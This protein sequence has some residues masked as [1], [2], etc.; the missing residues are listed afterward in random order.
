MP[1]RFLRR[2]ELPAK[3]G[4]LFFGVGIH[5]RLLLEGL[6]PLAFFDQL[7]AHLI[8]VVLLLERDDR[9]L[10]QVPQLLVPLVNCP[11]IDYGHVRFVQQ[12]PLS[13]TALEYLE[14][15]VKISLEGLE[16]AWGRDLL[17]DIVGG[18]DQM[19]QDVLAHNVRRLLPLFADELLDLVLL[20]EATPHYD[21]KLAHMQKL[22]TGC[23]HGETY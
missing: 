15:V 21:L 12:Q 6:P 20:A 8:V 3:P 19:V 10:P 11:R 14:V 1:R 22:Q 2:F 17:L 5:D 23:Q 4:L 16:L 7:R 18:V 9:V 13:V